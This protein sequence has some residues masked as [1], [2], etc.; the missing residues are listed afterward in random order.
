MPRNVNPF[1]DDDDELP[2][3]FPVEDPY[4][5]LKAR[6]RELEIQLEVANRK[7]GE[8]VDLGA[9]LAQSSDSMKLQLIMAGALTIPEKLVKPEEF[10]QE[11]PRDQF[12]AIVGGIEGLAHNTTDGTCTDPASTGAKLLSLIDSLKKLGPYLKKSW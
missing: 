12:V 7:W 4:T 6:I 1:F 10:K 3:A 9:S 11:N 8:A 2:Y 5:H